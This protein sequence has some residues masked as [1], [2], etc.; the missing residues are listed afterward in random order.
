[1]HW[2]ERVTPTH[3]RYRGKIDGANTPALEGV[4]SIDREGNLY[5]VSV[6]SYKQTLSTLYRAAL[7]RGA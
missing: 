2:A 1:L 4:P 7:P 5:F 6:R 3:F